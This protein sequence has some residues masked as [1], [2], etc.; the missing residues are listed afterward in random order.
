MQVWPLLVT[1]V[2][3]LPLYIYDEREMG[4][5]AAGSGQSMVAPPFA[6]GPFLWFRGTRWL[7]IP[8]AG[9]SIGSAGGCGAANRCDKRLL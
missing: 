6:T 3:A 7:L 9:R 2:G 1:A 8:P 5:L 4:E